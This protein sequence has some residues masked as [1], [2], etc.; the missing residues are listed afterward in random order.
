MRKKILKEKV[1][2]KGL[3]EILLG[4]QPEPYH[5]P[6]PCDER[7]SRQRQRADW[8]TYPTNMTHLG[9]KILGETAKR[10]YFT[11]TRN[12]AFMNVTSESKTYRT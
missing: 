2:E 6:V 7:E 3:V 1:I 5:E 10:Y 8:R 9:D 4:G 12:R 11:D